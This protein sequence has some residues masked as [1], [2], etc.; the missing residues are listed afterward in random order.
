MSDITTATTHPS[1]TLRTGA[2][3]PGRA[4]VTGTP[5]FG[6]TGYYF[7]ALF[8]GAVLA[9]WP[10]YLAR[11]PRGGDWYTHAH[12]VV[13]V[14]WCLLLIVQP[15]VI[16]ARRRDLHRRLGTLSRIVAPVFVVVSLLLAHAHT[17]AVDDPRFV[18][19]APSV[20]L[21]LSATLQFAVAYILALRFQQTTALHARFMIATGLTMIDPVIVRVLSFY[22][23]PLPHPLLYQVCGYGLCDAVL[24]LLAWRPALSASSRWTFLKGVAAFPACHAAWFTVVQGPQW[25]AFTAWFRALPLT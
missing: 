14:M 8:G 22:A 9:F 7:L 11:L 4:F 25:T 3:H 12:A 2:S 1:H 18:V 17:L 20:F 16:R 23:P 19:R 13:A 10:H 6:N 21:G 24:I 15:F 5:A